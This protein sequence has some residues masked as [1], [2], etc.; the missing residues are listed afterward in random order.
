MAEFDAPGCF[1][2]SD[3]YLSSGIAVYNKIPYSWY[4]SK[5]FYRGNE[6]KA[7]LVAMKYQNFLIDGSKSDL[8]ISFV[9]I[10]PNANDIIYENVALYYK[11]LIKGTDLKFVVMGDF[12]RNPEKLRKCFN[13]KLGLTNK[14]QKISESTHNQTGI[15]DLIYTNIDT[16][17]C[18]VLDS[19]TK[20]D[21]RPIFVSI[22][23]NCP[24]DVHG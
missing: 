20:T 3:E 17:V 8:L 21:H 16:A 9:Y 10:L 13:A 2:S 22:P 6:I 14:E 23:R 12:N 5:Q 11:D 19:L 24:T 4:D 18:G 7:S 15:I 1:S